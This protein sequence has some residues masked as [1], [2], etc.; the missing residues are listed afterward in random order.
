MNMKYKL[1][2]SILILVLLLSVTIDTGVLNNLHASDDALIV[3]IENIHSNLVMESFGLTAD[4]L[5]QIEATAG[6]RSSKD[7]LYAYPWILDADSRKLVWEFPVEHAKRHRKNKLRIEEEIFLKQGNYEVYYGIDPSKSINIRKLG[8]IFKGFF[9]GF[10]RSAKYSSFFTVKIYAARGSSDMRYVTTVKPSEDEQA[11]VQ[12]IEMGD[13]AYQQQGFSLNRD[14]S[15]RIYTI[16]EGYKRKREM[17]DYGWIIDAHSRRRVWEMKTRDCEHAGGAEKNL[18]FDD[19]IR[20][21]AGDYIAYYVTDGNHSYDEWNVMAPYDPRHWGLTIW[22]VGIDY[23]DSSVKPYHESEPNRPIVEITR[24]RDNEYESQGFTLTR[25]TKLRIYALGEYSYSNRY[26]VDYGW[27]E[28][29]RTRRRVWEMSYRDTQHAGGGRKNRYFDGIISL[30]PGNYMAYYITDDSHSYRDWNVGPP[31]DPEA[32]GITIWGAGEDF[33]LDSVQ[34]YREEEDPNLLVQIIRIGDDEY[35]QEEFTLNQPTRIHIYA[36]GE[37][38][39]YKMYDYGW[40]EDDKSRTV[41]KMKYRDTDHAGGARKN[42]LFSDS[43]VLARGTYYAGYRTDDS[44]SYR[45]WNT[46]APNDPVHWGITITI[47]D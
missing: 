10:D 38:D 33:T 7:E 1:I 25:P 2:L 21:S 23:S 31:Y 14:M 20:L 28:E 26:M 36:I 40:I 30:P 29:A 39:Q 37:G 18:K 27:I 15:L 5:I 24:M 6:C 43:I 41:W 22:G 47:A 42:R 16:G 32:W 4:I 11:I 46:S 35:I 3:E 17:Y 13:D 9:E 45:D 19:I 8:D 12:M 44:H 34:R